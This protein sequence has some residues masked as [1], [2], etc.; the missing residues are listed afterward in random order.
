MRIFKWVLLAAVLIQLIP[1]GRTHWNPLGTREPA[2]NSPETR[3]LIR[4]A[5]FDCHSNTTVWP[6][7]S[8]IAPVSWLVQRDVNGGRRHL[9][10]SEWDL[11][12]RHSKD[13]AQ[14]VREGEMPPWFYLPMHPAAKLTPAEK[15]ALIDGVEKSLG[16]QSGPEK[17]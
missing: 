5:C 12:Q 11:P 9:N 10:F 1:F 17:Q 2:W 3:E 13:V 7:Y 6:W 15:Q 8:H 4:R 16:P 14:Q